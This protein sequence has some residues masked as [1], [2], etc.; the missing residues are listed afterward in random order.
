MDEADWLEAVNLLE[1]AHTEEVLNQEEHR[2]LAI[3]DDIEKW[4]QTLLGRQ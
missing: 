2:T 4:M 3:I 1:M